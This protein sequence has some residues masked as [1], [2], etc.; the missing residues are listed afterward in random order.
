M[1][2]KPAIRFIPK[3]REN[4]SLLAWVIAVMVYL[5]GLALA[6]GFGVKNTFSGWTSELTQSISIQITA[7]HR[8]ERER[9]TGE[10]LALL[11]QT[12]GIATARSLNDD[13]LADLLEPWLGTGGLTED[14]PVP[15]M[16]DVTLTQGATLNL[17]ALAAQIRTVAPDARL[18]DHQQWIGRLVDLAGAVEWTAAGIVLLIVLSTVAV[19][20]LGTQAGLAAHRDSIEIMHLV[21]AE[22]KTIWAEF[23]YRFMSHGLKGGLVGLVLAAGTVSLLI[24]L[25]ARLGS[26]IVPQ[27][28][29]AL[30]QWAVLAALP[31]F[32]ALLAVLT[33]RFTVIRALARLM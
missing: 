24:R 1:S 23:R 19:V 31:F 15:A 32:A 18:D 3:G 29:L 28:D 30:W 26:G 10:A 21:G 9:Q 22:D 8:A 12:P 16:I 4:G 2:L 17:E 25:A 6:G 13:E 20:M 33:A 11:L 5:C 7:E 14:L 27:F